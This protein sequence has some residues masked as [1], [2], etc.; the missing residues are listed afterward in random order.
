MEQ[1]FS[2][3][4]LDEG[5]KLKEGHGGLPREGIFWV[6]VEK[7][8]RGGSVRKVLVLMCGKGSWKSVCARIKHGKKLCVASICSKASGFLF[9]LV[10]P[11]KSTVGFVS[12]LNQ[13]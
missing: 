12:N 11:P 8:K 10:V 7:K 4:S 6:Y 2:K 9:Q 5:N 13:F 3:L 1:G